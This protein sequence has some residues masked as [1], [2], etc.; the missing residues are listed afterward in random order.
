MSSSFPTLRQ[1][2][3]AL[4]PRDLWAIGLGLFGATLLSWIYLVGLAED[5]ERMSATGMMK[6]RPWEARDF[7]LMFVM[8]A[9]M[10]VGMMVP[11]ATPTALLYASVA[12]KA[13]G[14]GSPV[15]PTFVFVT[16]YVALWALFSVVATAGQWGLERAALLS[17]GMAS[18]SPQLSGLLLIGVG[19]Y[20]LTPAKQACLDHCR[21]PA[22][23]MAEHWHPGHFGALRMGAI[24]GAFCLGCCW[25]L[26]ALLFF[27]GV[28]DLLWI[29]GLTIFVLVEKLL[30]HGARVAR[31]SGIVLLVAG[32]TILIDAVR[33]VA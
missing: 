11:S 3:A 5:M 27:G 25:F 33:Q 19:L 18:A 26:M 1:G 14:Q 17:P 22:R 7:L 10:M 31:G 2:V 13:K 20:Q 23:F 9:V 24:H 32:L 28:M 29:A 12:R 21:S 4:R 16:G 15:A 30:P 8:W 6:L